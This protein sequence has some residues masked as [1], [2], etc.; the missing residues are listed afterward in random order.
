MAEAGTTPPSGGTAQ[1]DQTPTDPQ[2]AD[3]APSG[4]SVDDLE[5]VL[6]DAIARMN[7]KER[8]MRERQTGEK[9]AAQLTEHRTHLAESIRPALTVIGKPEIA[10]AFAKSDR[11]SD[12]IDD[13]A[14]LAR[15][16]GLLQ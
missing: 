8:N 5:P 7:R 6:L 12:T 15:L 14:D 13:A 4:R 2:P 1:P 10:E 11:G 3:P 9:L 16:K